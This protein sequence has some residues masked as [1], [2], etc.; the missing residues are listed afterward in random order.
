MQTKITKAVSTA[1]SS[2]QATEKLPQDLKINI[3]VTRS[4]DKAHGDFACNIAM[5]LA[6]QAQMEPRQL[7]E[8]LVSSLPDD[9][10]IT[11]VEIAGPGFLNFYVNENLHGEILDSILQQN[12]SYGLS[13]KYSNKKVQIIIL[14]TYTF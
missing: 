14:N 7:A 8:L 12:E 10:N 4:K 13:K 6:K 5:Q 9:G 11:K 2:L 3:Q 1:I